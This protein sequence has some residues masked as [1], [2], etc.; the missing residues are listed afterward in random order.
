M[1]PQKHRLKQLI[2]PIVGNL[3]IK[4]PY[5]NKKETTSSKITLTPR[6]QKPTE[7]IDLTHD[8]LHEVN[9]YI[10][11]KLNIPFIAHQISNKFLNF[12]KFIEQRIAVPKEMTMYDKAMIACYV[13]MLLVNA[14]S[15][16]GV[17]LK[18]LQNAILSSK[19]C[20]EAKINADSDKKDFSNITEDATSNIDI[21]S[22]TAEIDNFNEKSEDKINDKTNLNTSEHASK[23]ISDVSP[24]NM[25]TDSSNVDNIKKN[26]DSG[27][28][29]KTS[30][31]EYTKSKTSD[32][33]NPINRTAESEPQDSNIILNSD[34]N[35]N[36]K[37]TQLDPP[38]QND[39]ADDQS[40]VAK[41]TQLNIIHK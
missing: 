33:K 24:K 41:I 8:E 6:K 18:A 35:S 3:A 17:R 12:W 20:A 27:G 32:G 38:D 14:S 10:I 36:P 25:T 28:D 30:A 26:G 5:Q 4:N 7:E 15:T 19:S 9:E 1:A 2:I 23:K 13:N 34:N 40:T 21:D 31:S 29:S 22:N 39:Q 37:V 16:D 11:K